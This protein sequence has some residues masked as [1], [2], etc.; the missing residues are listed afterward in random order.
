MKNKI[1]SSKNKRNLQI[2]NMKKDRE[3]ESEDWHCIKTKSLKFKQLLLYDK[4]KTI[5]TK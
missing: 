4:I 2:F 1:T 5:K 3:V